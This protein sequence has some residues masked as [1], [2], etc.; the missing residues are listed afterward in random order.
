MMM[1]AMLIP[2][3]SAATPI[4]NREIDS[5]TPSDRSTVLGCFGS[6]WNGLTHGSLGFCGGRVS[7]L[8][9]TPSMLALAHTNIMKNKPALA[10][11]GATR[12]DPINPHRL[13][14]TEAPANPPAIEP[15]NNRKNLY[16]LTCLGPGGTS[17]QI[18]QEMADRNPDAVASATTTMA[19]S[20]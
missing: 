13:A 6:E 5:T 10:A 16:T 20:T 12:A 7:S 4:A 2:G 14:P 15:E 9:T 8:A 1:S 11:T 19:R 17:F 3:A 18:G